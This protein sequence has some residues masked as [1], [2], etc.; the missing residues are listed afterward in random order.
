MPSSPYSNLRARLVER[1]QD[2]DGDCWMGIDETDR[3]G[4]QRVDIWVPGLHVQGERGSGRRRVM[5]HVAMWCW[6][7]WKCRNAND[8][9]LAYR[10]LRESGLELDH[11]CEEPS[12]RN[13]GHLEPMTHVENIAA[14]RE[15][16]V[17]VE[18]FDDE[19]E[20]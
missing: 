14:S 5:A 20:F 11:S 17:P 12:C 2:A 15:R 13:P 1:C 3:Y 8:L 4:Y 16:R 19:K 9:W 6:D 18:V 7:H 10:E